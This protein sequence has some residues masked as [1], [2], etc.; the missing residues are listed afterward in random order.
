MN[1]NQQNHTKKTSNSRETRAS[2]QRFGKESTK[3]LKSFT[4]NQTHEVRND[5]QTLP[6][7]KNHNFKKRNAKIF[8]YRYFSTIKIIKEMVKIQDINSNVSKITR[9][10]R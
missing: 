8:E 3:S 1:L 6:C 4:K 2:K 9:N 5:I 7:Q 10:Q